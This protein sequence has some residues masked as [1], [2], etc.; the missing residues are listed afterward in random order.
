[1]WPSRRGS[2]SI[3][4]LGSAHD[5]SEVEAL[6][7]A[8]RQRL[9]E[10]HGAATAAEKARG[11]IYYQY[12][13]DRAQRTLRGIDEQVAKAEN[14]VAGKAPVK[15][16]RFITMSGARGPSLAGPNLDAHPTSAPASHRSAGDHG[17]REFVAFFSSIPMRLR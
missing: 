16:N 5:E 1:M 3:E 13:H 9:A 2:R 10:G 4:H 6:K 7:A 14:A 8:D 17:V 15:H 12:R 11:I